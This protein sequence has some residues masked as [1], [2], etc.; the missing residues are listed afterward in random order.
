MRLTTSIII[1]PRA[2]ARGKAIGFVRLFV[3]QHKIA[4]SGDLGVSIN[5]SVR[6]VGK[7][8][9]PDFESGHERHKP[10]CIYPPRLSTT[11]RGPVYAMCARAAS[12]AHAR[13]RALELDV[14][15]GRQVHKLMYVIYDALV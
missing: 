11:P 15:K 3:Y 2:C 8:T 7:L 12:T 9:L 6:K 14:G 1:T 4:R 10:A 5:Y 13:T